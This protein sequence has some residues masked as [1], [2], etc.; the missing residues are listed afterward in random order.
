MKI[1]NLLH[2]YQPHNQQKDI[3]DRIVHESYLPIINMMQEVP[4]AKAT[5]NISGVLLQLLEYNNYSDVLTG[6][7]HLLEKEQIEL[8]G[9]AMYHAFL[10]LLPINEIK[11]QVSLN[12]EVSTRLFGSLYHPKGFFTPELAINNTV[13][14]VIYQLGYEWI[15]APQVS[16]GPNKPGTSQTYFSDEF[17]INV[18]FRNKRV[19][20]L[21]LSAASRSAEDLWKETEDLHSTESY[22]FT[23]MDAET[24]GHHRV[25][26]DALLKDIF[27][28][29]HFEPLLASELFSLGMKRSPV[30][31]RPSTWTNEEQDFWLDKEQTQI[32]EARSFILWKDP[33][34]PIHK[35]QWDFLHFV[36][37]R[38]NTTKDE[39]NESW[40]KARNLMDKAISSD[41]FWWASAKPWWSLEMV[42]QGAFMLLQVIKTLNPEDTKSVYEA[43][44][45][46]RKILDQAFDWQRSGYIRIR[47]LENSSTFMKEPF[48]MRAPAEWYNQIVLEFEDEMMKAANNRDFEKAVKWRDAL[49]K[50]EKGTDI[51]DVLHVVDELWSA[52]NIPSVK[53]FLEHEWNEFS[54]YARGKFRGVVSKEDFEKWKKDR[55]PPL[56]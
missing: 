32:T 7:K 8:T 42:E 3:L 50:L 6:L 43:D 11:R 53:P 23:V 18:I 46:Y 39:N 12:D 28:C 44:S 34:N 2:F 27:T 49:V 20:S 33:E 47:H 38:L 19:S 54:D 37:T 16:F 56:E 22:W 26:H 25:G 55:K 5:F 35:L 9:T 14:D 52:R 24:F 4:T 21:I 29:K 51:Y 1:V 13:L 17:G 48:N 36:L 10:P 40:I 45:F 31:L 30:K 41:Q 15:A